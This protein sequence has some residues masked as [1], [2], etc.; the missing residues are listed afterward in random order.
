MATFVT[1]PHTLY[2][3]GNKKIHGQIWGFLIFL[4]YSLSNKNFLQILLLEGSVGSSAPLL[5]KTDIDLD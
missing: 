1:Y 4:P 5:N 2:F 3:K